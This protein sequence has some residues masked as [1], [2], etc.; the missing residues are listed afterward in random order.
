MA[1]QVT[2]DTVGKKEDISDII[3]NIAPMETPFQ[4]L[5][6][7]EKCHNTIV[8]FQE[9]DLATVGTNAAVEGADA[10][11]SNHVPTIMRSNVTQIFT[12]TVKV[13]GSNEAS[14]A[15]GRK[16]ELAYQLEKKSKEL[17]RDEE[18]AFV[19]TAQVKVIGDSATARQLDSAQSMLTQGGNVVDA[20]AVTGGLV[21]ALLLEASELVYTSGAEAKV[22][23]FHSSQAKVVAGYAQADGFRVKF[24]DAKGTEFSNYLTVY[25]DP[26]GQSIKLI[27]NRFIKADTAIVFDPAMFKIAELR[28]TFKETLA[29]TGDA[30]THQ[31]VNE[32]TL[33][34]LNFK[35]GALIENLQSPA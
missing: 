19:G 17:K 27:P 10:D 28:P 25:T 4:S 32:L 5:I 22:C 26:L 21:E 9:D 8:Q 23:M 24:S 3:V 33:K 35:S 11:A 12:K 1:T 14:S 30:E 31:I 13:S 16:S 18:H 34:L 20:T 6:A 29:K 7:R 2:Y 15:Y